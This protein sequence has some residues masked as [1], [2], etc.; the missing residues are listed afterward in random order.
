MAK[1]VTDR[2]GATELVVRAAETHAEHVGKVFE[3]E[4]SRYVLG[5][6]KMPDIGLALKLV[7]RALRDRRKTL[8]DAHEREVES[9]R[10]AEDDPTARLS[11]ELS[12]IRSLIEGTYGV[13]GLQVLG[14]DEK[15]EVEPT[16]VLSRARALFWK[17]TSK[18]TQLPVPIRKGFC[19]N[20]RELA[21]E[22]S[23]LIDELD[24]SL[25]RVAAGTSSG[26]AAREAKARALL[27]NDD[28]FSRGAEFISAA[29]RLVGDE[30]VARRIRP[31]AHRP[32]RT[33]ENFSDPRD[34]EGGGT[35]P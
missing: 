3:A 22:L 13:T 28:L 16:A 11:A 7:A 12:W 26:P 31:S 17:L 33:A 1:H 24:L 6:E 5:R 4:F 2:Q 8:T 19:I 18:D 20:A 34:G 29:F 27:A 30:D 25:Q 14:L 9:S 21:A 23:E 15:P 10:G 35:L 32:G